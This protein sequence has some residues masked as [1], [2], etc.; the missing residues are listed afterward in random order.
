MI[1]GNDQTTQY[2]IDNE[3]WVLTS[4]PHLLI[5]TRLQYIARKIG[6]I[7]IQTINKIIYKNNVK[8]YKMKEKNSY[9]WNYDV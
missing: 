3:L 6:E 1:D 2:L 9:A 8:W 4:C 7:N 5:Y